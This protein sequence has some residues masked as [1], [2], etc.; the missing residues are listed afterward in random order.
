MREARYAVTKTKFQW[1]LMREARYAVTKHGSLLFCLIA[2]AFVGCEKAGEPAN[3]AEPQAERKDQQSVSPPL[4]MWSP[5]FT[6][7][8]LD[9]CIES[10][11]RDGSAEGARKCKCVVEKAS[12]TIPEQRFKAIRTDPE[13][14][15]L[16][17]QIGVAC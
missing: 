1:R 17:K 9:E 3:K 5:E 11:T 15:E 4:A 2:F 8:T 13:V 14:K 12:T 6:K 7:Q 10:A 16:I